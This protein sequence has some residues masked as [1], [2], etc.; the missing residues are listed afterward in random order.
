MKKSLLLAT[1]AFLGSTLLAVPTV[2]DVIVRQQWPWRSNVRVDFLLDGIGS[3]DVKFTFTA[4]NG[5]TSLGTI[6]DAAIVGDKYADMNGLKSVSIDPAY[7]PALQGLGDIGTFRL[8]ISC[9]EVGRLLYKV[10]DLTKT[11]GET[12]HIRYITETELKTGDWG[13]WQENVVSGVQSV[14]W[15]AP[16]A[17]DNDYKKKFLVL[18]RV[19]PGTFG[20][21]ASHVSTTLTKGYWIGIFTLTGAQYDYVAA[22]P[23]GGSATYPQRNV[24]QDMM[25]GS[26]VSWPGD[27]HKVAT[28]SWLGRLCSKVGE[29]GFD[30][31]TEAQWEYACRAG[32][33]DDTIYRSDKTIDQVAQ[34]GGSCQS[35]GGKSPNAWGLF[36]MIGNVWEH[37]LV[38]SSG[39]NSVVEGGYDPVG[40]ATPPSANN[41]IIRGGCFRS[42]DTNLKV[43]ARTAD[44]SS[45]PSA[46]SDQDGFRLVQNDNW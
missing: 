45:T 42:G 8:E 28:D 7:A 10:I 43:V 18:R 2:S 1:S 16:A 38:W 39:N 12:D 14:L 5:E 3:S 34:H 41:R 23:L 44:T 9:T 19:R 22:S 40:P 20:L 35:V 26:S 29:S 33:T 31:P 13:N 15:V 37:T 32:T 36:D 27:G 24:S 11:R 21:G 46:T 17:G 30:L 4:Y 25:R 6:P